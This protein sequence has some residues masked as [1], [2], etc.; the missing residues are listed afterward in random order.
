[1]ISI[2][3]LREESDLFESDVAKRYKHFNPRSPRGER[4]VCNRLASVFVAFQSTLSAR[5]ATLNRRLINHLLI[6]FQSTLSARRATIVFVDDEN[7]LE[8]FNPRSPRGERRLTELATTVFEW[9]SIHALREESDSWNVLCQRNVHIYFNPRSPRGERLDFFQFL[10]P[11]KRISIHA[12][13]EE[14]DITLTVHYKLMIYFNP[15]SPRGERRHR[16]KTPN[17]KV[18]ISIHALREESDEQWTE[19]LKVN[20]WISIH[21]LREESDWTTYKINY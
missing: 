17:R 14:S 15:R 1:M 13:R 9:I 11:V 2:H 3:A 12:L 5:R 10:M 16:V 21:A 4:R 19:A 7:G 18:R 6:K 8:N 20:L